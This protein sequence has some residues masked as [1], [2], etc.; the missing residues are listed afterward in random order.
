M[1]QCCL[2]GPRGELISKEVKNKCS[3][4]APECGSLIALKLRPLFVT[5]SFSQLP[6]PSQTPFHNYSLQV[7]TLLLPELKSLYD[8]LS[9]K[10]SIHMTS[11]GSLQ[12]P[13]NKS[14]GLHSLVLASLKRRIKKGSSVVPDE[15]EGLHL[16]HFIPLETD[17]VWKG[18]FA[19]T[20]VEDRALLLSLVDSVAG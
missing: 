20:G 3:R 8:I 9:Q 5:L 19:S 11:W 4:S 13:Q 2:A 6:I 12:Q 10:M 14:F 18:L 17:P 7:T 16:G 15:E 1:F